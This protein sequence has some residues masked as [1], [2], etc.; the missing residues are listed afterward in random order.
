MSQT[1]LIEP[2]LSDE[3]A[4]LAKLASRCIM[5]ALDHSRA[6]KIILTDDSE[7]TTGAPVLELPPQTLRLFAQVLSMMSQRKFISLVHQKHELSTQEAAACLN[8]SRPY[9]IKQLES[10][11]LPFRKVGRHRRVE[12]ANLM[13]FKKTMHRDSE[14]ALQ[15]LATQAQELGL[16]Y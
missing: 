13:E 1:D 8:V 2:V 16:G 3:E 12:F 10:G 4:E 15:D 5:T 14:A 11:K 7:N 9:L 6:K